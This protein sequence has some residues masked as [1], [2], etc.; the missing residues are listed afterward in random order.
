MRK[1]LITAGL[2]VSLAALILLA[3]ACN[4]EKAPLPTFDEWVTLQGGKG[5]AEVV[6]C[7]TAARHIT[8]RM[9]EGYTLLNVQGFNLDNNHC[10]LI[11]EKD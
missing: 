4:K 7:M 10:I 11:W 8:K 5:G 1:A 9:H 2:G 3:V 6:K